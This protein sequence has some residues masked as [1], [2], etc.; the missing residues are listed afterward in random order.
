VELESLPGIGT[1]VHCLLPVQADAAAAV[2]APVGTAAP[3]RGERVLY[4]DDEPSLV[5]IGRRQLEALGYEVQTFGDPAGA[6]AAIRAEP[7]RFQV[8]VTDYLMPRMNGLQFAR[9]LQETQPGLP[10]ILLSGFVGDFTPEELRQGGVV[11]VLQKPVAYD[12]LAT[13]LRASLAGGS[14]P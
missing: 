3:G 7:G 10:V 9:A 11:R 1:T 12:G 5:S 6:L 13:A 2:V 14:T 4:V 8:V